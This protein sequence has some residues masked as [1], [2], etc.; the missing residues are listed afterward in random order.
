QCVRQKALETNPL[1]PDISTWPESGHL[2]LASTRPVDNFIFIRRSAATGAAHPPIAVP[3]A[4]HAREQTELIPSLVHSRDNETPR[5]SLAHARV[6]CGRSPRERVAH[7]SRGKNAIVAN[8]HL[9]VAIR[10]QLVTRLS[11]SR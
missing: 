5:L 10:L 2:N 11:V 4:F 1:N 6:F 9:R 7:S 3:H 8:R